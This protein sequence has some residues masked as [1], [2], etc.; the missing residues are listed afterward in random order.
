MAI[1]LHQRLGM[2]RA[3]TGLSTDGKHPYINPPALSSISAELL[4]GK[5][6][7]SLKGSDIVEKGIGR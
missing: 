3:T 6:A 1:M 7:L 4:N 2:K 5:A